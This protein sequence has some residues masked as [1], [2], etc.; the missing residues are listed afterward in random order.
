M[1]GLLATGPPNFD[2]YDLIELLTVMRH[3]AALG[4]CDIKELTDLVSDVHDFSFTL[5]EF[6]PYSLD[7]LARLSR[8][9]D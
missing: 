3:H 7:C 9:G 6:P 4:T 1:N 2:I 5:G 8:Q